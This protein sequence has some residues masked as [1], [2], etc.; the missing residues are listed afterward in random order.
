MATF[1]EMQTRV[2]QIIIDCPTTVTAHIPS[3]I[4]EATRRLQT[5]HNFQVCKALSSVYTTTEGT[6]VLG[7]LPSNWIRI[8]G[9]PYEIHVDG[10][11]REFAFSLDRADVEREYGS[12]A[13]GQASTDILSGPPRVILQSES[14]ADSGAANL[15][16]YPLPD[17][18]S[19]YE[20]PNAGEYR[21]RIP[22][23]KFLTELSA[24][25]DTNW[26]TVHA[27]EWIVWMAAAEGFFSDHDEERGTLWTQK[28]MGKWQEI[29]KRD[30]LEQ[31]AMVTH[32][33]PSSDVLG[34]R[35]WTRD[36]YHRSP[37][38]GLR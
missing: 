27:N 31:V 35:L 8:R 4:K 11:V 23:W 28:A 33:V 16:L 2:Q 22:Y 17:G 24:A 34:S 30:K 15:E 7:A 21:I 20:A 26:F 1:G 32:L 29:V 3:F 37:D 12:D 36:S 5:L 25:G 38:R 18:N 10:Q 19:L 14:T 9:N 13:G 6:R